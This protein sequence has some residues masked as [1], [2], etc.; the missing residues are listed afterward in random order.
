[1]AKFYFDG[2]IRYRKTKDI[3][4]TG[5]QDLVTNKHA[6]YL[7]FPRRDLNHGTDC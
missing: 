4:M 5:V 7:E 2:Q 1:M 3:M 6:T